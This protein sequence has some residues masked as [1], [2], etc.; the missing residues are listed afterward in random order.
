MGYGSQIAY[1]LL[2]GL[3]VA[4][5]AWTVTR[6]E[7]FKEFRESLGLY[8]KRHRNSLWRQKLA[9]LPTC[10]YC[11][12]HYVAALFVGLF[13]FK[14]LT[15]NWTGYVASLFTV[16]LIANVYISG[17]NLLRVALRRATAVADR[18]EATARCQKRWAAAVDNMEPSA[19]NPSPARDGHGFLNGPWSPALFQGQDGK[20]ISPRDSGLRDQR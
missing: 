1:A 2:L 6:E 7:V 15:E 18:E 17:Y 14:M 4:C 11:F 16:V 13:Q 12:S 10:P 20:G 19:W 3:P 8:Q 9:Y 5:V